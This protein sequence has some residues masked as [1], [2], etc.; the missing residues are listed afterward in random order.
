MA[1]LSEEGFEYV[2]TQTAGEFLSGLPGWFEIAPNHRVETPQRFVRMFTEMMTP[3]DYDEKFKVFP[4]DKKVDQMVTLGPISFYTL[5]AHHMVPFFGQAWVGYIP[6]EKIAGLS[7]FARAVKGI[8][9]GAHVQ[10][11]LTADIATYLEEKLE[12]LGVALVMRA[13]HM[14]MAMRG[15]K[16]PNVITTTSS[17]KGVFGDHTRTAKAEFLAW[18]QASIK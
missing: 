2:M 8:C 12:P 16:E 1:Q 18:V 13:E 14:C 11:E 5:C 17:M 6:D 7:K 10:E 15:I 3:T 9:K 4:N